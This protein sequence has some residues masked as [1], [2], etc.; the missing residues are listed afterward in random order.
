MAM[1]A[2]S[3]IRNVYIIISILYQC[4]ISAASVL[5]QYCISAASV[6]HQYCSKIILLD[7]S[8]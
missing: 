6:L 5:Y 3:S 4:C 7:H 8:L 1:E 2:A